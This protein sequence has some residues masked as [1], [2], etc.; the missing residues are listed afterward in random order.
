MKTKNVIKALGIVGLAA[1]VM[2]AAGDTFAQSN[3]ATETSITDVD[4]S[5]MIDAIVDLFNTPAGKVIIVAGSIAGLAAYI[6]TQKV[7]TLIIVAAL[8]GSPFIMSGI[9]TLVAG[10]GTYLESK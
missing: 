5:S 1:G 6:F 9:E 10:S 8:L 2:L 7:W 4:A 3:A